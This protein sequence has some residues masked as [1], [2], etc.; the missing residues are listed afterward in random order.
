MSNIKTTYDIT[1]WKLILDTSIPPIN[2]N[3][4]PRNIRRSR[5]QQP[6]H[7]APQFAGISHPP[8]RN[9]IHPLFLQRR[10]LL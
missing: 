1:N 10:V 4:R 2:P 8:H 9:L 5:T 3:L 6:N 7:H